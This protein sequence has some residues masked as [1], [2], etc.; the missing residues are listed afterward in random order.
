MVTLDTP[1]N[2]GILH[3][4]RRKADPPDAPMSEPPSSIRDPYYHLG[5]HPDLVEWLWRTLTEQL[6][7][8]CRWVVYRRPALVHPRTGVVLGFAG[9]THMYGLR[10]PEPELAEAIAAGAQRQ[11]VVQ[12]K[13]W[14]D[15]AETGPEWVFG[16][17][18]RRESAWAHA[19]Y[20]AAG[21]P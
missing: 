20:V 9:G 18:D 21:S 3:V 17:W 8:D 2:S 19:A 13:V 11:Y 6:P 12:G 16:R 5:T 1:A 14:M 4:L 7:E 10:L 15:L